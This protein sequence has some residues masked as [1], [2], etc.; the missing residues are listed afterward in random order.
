MS[1]SSSSYG[2]AYIL[3]DITGVLSPSS[4]SEFV[5]IYGRMRLLVRRTMPDRPVYMIFNTTS[6]R[7][8]TSTST[9]GQGNTAQAY[10][11]RSSAVSLQP[12]IALDFGLGPGLGAAIVSFPSGVSVPMNSYM[13]R[14]M[15]SSKSRIFRASDGSEYCWTHRGQRDQEWACTNQVGRLVSYYS[16]K[17]LGEPAYSRSSGC[18]LTIEEAYVNLAA[19]FLATFLIMRHITLSGL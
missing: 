6:N 14:A 13:A 3:E 18:S 1:S 5:D 17:P 11:A 15:G 12:L 19:E 7:T 2:L 9:Q 4:N 8:N 16:L 10:N